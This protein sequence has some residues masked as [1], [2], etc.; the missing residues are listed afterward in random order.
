MYHQQYQQYEDF[1]IYFILVLTSTTYYLSFS[2]TTNLEELPT[3]V[4]AVFRSDLCGTAYAV[5]TREV[6]PFWNPLFHCI[7][8]KGLSSTLF[9]IYISKLLRMVAPFIY[10]HLLV[11]ILVDIVVSMSIT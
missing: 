9:S 11:S 3:A 6:G 8:W 7:L 4:H 1:T 5:I 10:K 2:S